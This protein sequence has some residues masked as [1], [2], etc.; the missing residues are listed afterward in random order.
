[1]N[2][3]CANEVIEALSPL[4]KSCQPHEVKD[5][6]MILNCAFLIETHLLDAFEKEIDVLDKRYDNQLT[7]RLIGPL[8]PYSFKTLEIEL[9]DPGDVED[10]R[11]LFSLGKTATELEIKT[12]YRE[13]AKT[14]HPDR[15][16]GDKAAQNRF[17][18]FNKAFE[19]LKAYCRGGA[20][21]FEPVDIQ[22]W[23]AVREMKYRAGTR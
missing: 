12:R 18:S 20:C 1:M 19:I 4:S 14:L 2:T 17:E 23:I 16:P 22:N 7:F 9:L 11:I 10:A 5:D 3:V 8:P 21:S 13:M 6:T 15:F